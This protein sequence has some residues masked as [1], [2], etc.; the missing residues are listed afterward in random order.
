MLKEVNVDA[1]HQKLIWSEVTPL[2]IDESV[3]RIHREF[4]DFPTDLIEEHLFG[5]LEKECEPEEYTQDQMNELN[6]LVK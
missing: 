4:T 2:S 6:E 5:W 1:V 3:Q